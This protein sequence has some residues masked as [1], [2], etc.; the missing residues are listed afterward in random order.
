MQTAWW[1]RLTD[2]Y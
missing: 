2:L 1:P